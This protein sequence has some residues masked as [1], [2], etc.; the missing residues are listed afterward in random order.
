MI[1][2]NPKRHYPARMVIAKATKE[3]ARIWQVSRVAYK[4]PECERVRGR[5]RFGVGLGGI[6]PICNGNGK[7]GVGKIK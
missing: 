3:G 7:R 4:C 5:L 6:T 2:S 1:N